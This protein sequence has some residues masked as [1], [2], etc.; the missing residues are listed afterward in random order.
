M[1][2]VYL[3][4]YDVAEPKRLRRMFRTMK[5]YGDPL[6]YSVFICV[7]SPEEKLVL[8]SKAK[9]VINQRED[10][11]ML[12]RIGPEEGKGKEA[13]EFL[14]TTLSVQRRHCVVV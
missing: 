10:R 6:Q 2:S 7:L 8:V 14:G 3:A 1:R 12:A 4:F 5:G 13:L 11:F 9:D